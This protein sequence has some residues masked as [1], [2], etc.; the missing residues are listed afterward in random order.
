MIN[1]DGAIETA[2]ALEDAIDR[3]MDNAF[4]IGFRAGMEAAVRR[5]SQI[6]QTIEGVE[7]VDMEA[8]EEVAETI[9]A[10][11]FDDLQKEGW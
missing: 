1:I 9:R 10:K 7:C 5:L 3:G 6:R 8:V 2:K 4:E 11:P